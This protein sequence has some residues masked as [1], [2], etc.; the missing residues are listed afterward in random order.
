MCSERNETEHDLCLNKDN[1]EIANVER[2]KSRLTEGTWEGDLEM[3]LAT[4]LET[5]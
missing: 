3:K 4:T 2:T 5:N 1:L